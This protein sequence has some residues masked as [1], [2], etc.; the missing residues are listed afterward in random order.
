MR[1]TFQKPWGYAW[2]ST[3]LGC[4][5]VAGTLSS[6]GFPE[7]R[8]IQFASLENALLCGQGP[9]GNGVLLIECGSGGN[10][11]ASNTGAFQVLLNTSDPG[12]AEVDLAIGSI[13]T[14]PEPTMLGL[15]GV[16]LLAGGIAR[17]GRRSKI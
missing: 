4:S 12:T 3:P 11:N 1:N 6:G 10:F 15:L 17:R 2:S 8:I 7:T 14:I 16:A 5:G 13:R 9:L